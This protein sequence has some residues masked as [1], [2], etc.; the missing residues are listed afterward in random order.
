M[1]LAVLSLWTPSHA[2]WTDLFNGTDLDGWVQYG[3]A[4]DYFV[5]DGILY[6]VAVPDS[7]NSFLATRDIYSDFILEVEFLVDPKLN[8]GVQIR[9]QVN[10]AGLVYGYQVEIDPSD[11]AWSAGIYDE[12]RRGWMYPLTENKP[13][14]EAFRPGDW[15]TIRV[16]A[17]GA[18]IRTWI[19]GVEAAS[20]LDIETPEG[21]IALQV[22]S[23]NDAADAGIDIAF[24]SVRIITHNPERHQTPASD[25][26][27]L[28]FIPNA[29]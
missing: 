16:E 9:S 27:Q 17:L 29:Q 7:P 18:S 19:N 1:Q 5:E 21:F 12:G 22:H 11:R 4:A 26:K 6:G 13:G 2:Q 8:S 25:L 14:Q 28:N 10:D 24:R 23:I 15:K 20:V 3:G